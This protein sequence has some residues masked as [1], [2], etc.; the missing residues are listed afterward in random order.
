MSKDGDELL[1]ASIQRCYR[2]RTAV[3]TS[4]FLMVLCHA[5][6][7][8]GRIV[9]ERA[10]QSRKEGKRSTPSSPLAG[11]GK[12]R[13]LMSG[14]GEESSTM[15][16]TLTAEA[17]MRG[18]H[19]QQAPMW[20]YISPEQRIPQ[21]HPLRP[22]RTLVDAVLKDLSPG[23]SR[24]Y[25]KTGRPWVALERLLRALLLQVLYSIRSERQLM[26]QLD[27]NLLYRW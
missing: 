11:C 25:A 15:R 1:A 20:S 10:A 22:L 8:R 24:L 23:F 5:G 9:L 6:M 16:V 17:R 7:N 2:G 19:K 13:V 26:E 12:T 4:W 27:Y 14:H 3:R 21:D 18:D